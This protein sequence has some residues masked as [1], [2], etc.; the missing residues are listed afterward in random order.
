M[1]TP[2]LRAVKESRRGRRVTLLAS[3]QGAAVAEL[4]PEV[5][6]TIVYEAPWM[7]SSPERHD[8]R[9]D[10]LLAAQLNQ[11]SFDAAIIF[12]VYSQ[13]PLPAALICYLANIPLRL[14]HCRENPYQLLTDWIPDEAER[15]SG[16]HEVRRQL[17][18]VAQVGY[19][20]K[21]ERLGISFP[22]GT[23]QRVLKRAAK[24]GLNP[25][26]P[27]VVMHPGASAP[28]RRYPADSYGKAARLLIEEKNV[29]VVLTGSQGEIELAKQVQKGSGGRAISL[30]GQLD[31][32]ELAALLQAAPV[33]ISNNTGP[34]HLAAAVGTPVVDL[35]AL[36]NPQHTPWMVPSRVLNKDVPC[37][38]CYKS[39]CPEG[40]HLCLRGVT[41]RQV[42][43]AACELLPGSTPAA[44]LKRGAVRPASIL[45]TN[46]KAAKPKTGKTRR[47]TALPGKITS[48]PTKEVNP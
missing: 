6:K 16:R 3:P 27:W 2:A 14:A 41:P 36:T 1:T 40:H 18:L 17:D 15:D 8:S 47:G 7:K 39:I 33:V 48:S 42:V 22:T 9:D 30:A 26:A 24:L 35:Y 29:Q 37:K 20:A 31:M 32:A 13:N 43:K 44:R 38:Y 45:S 10:Y 12:T 28:S 4:I 11:G 21:D 5:D 34:A 19:A 25:S 23:S 46:A